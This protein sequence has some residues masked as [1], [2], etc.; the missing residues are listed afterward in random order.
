MCVNRFACGTFILVVEFHNVPE[1]QVWR[2]TSWLY[3][4]LPAFVLRVGGFVLFCKVIKASVFRSTQPHQPCS[5]LSYLNSTLMQQVGISPEASSPSDIN[6]L[7]NI[8]LIYLRGHSAGCE[9]V[10]ANYT[11]I[12]WWWISHCEAFQF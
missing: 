5:P 1:R 3:K 4:A 12:L 8:I 7:P 9:F 2:G 10:K 6:L 11:V